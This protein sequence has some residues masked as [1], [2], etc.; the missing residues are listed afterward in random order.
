VVSPRQARRRLVSEITTGFS[1][2]PVSW[3]LRFSGGVKQIYDRVTD[4]ATG[5]T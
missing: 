4:P 2:K 1:Q 3:F 5:E